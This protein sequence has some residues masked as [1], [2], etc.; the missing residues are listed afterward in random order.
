MPEKHVSSRM[1]K[2]VLE[3]YVKDL[4][5]SIININTRSKTNYQSLVTS[6][7]KIED[8]IAKDF[9]NDKNFTSKINNHKSLIKQI[10][11]NRDKNITEIKKVIDEFIKS[12]KFVSDFEKLKLKKLKEFTAWVVQ[13]NNTK[14]ELDNFRNKINEIFS[15]SVEDLASSAEFQQDKLNVYISI[16]S[17]GLIDTTGS[18][19]RDILFTL[20]KT[21]NFIELL[22]NNDS[23]LTSEKGM[24]NPLDTEILFPSN[25]FEDNTPVNFTTNQY[26]EFEM[27][28]AEKKEVKVQVK[29]L[30]D[31]RSTKK[32]LSK[33]K[34][35]PIRVTI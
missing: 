25:I 33:L 6:I 28:V 19:L 31:L 27:Y 34:I 22:A 15:K 35:N 1:I 3:P 23:S 16:L 4:A 32:S 17:L 13:S 9:I 12:E 29:K 2:L 5:I 14:V 7:L 18:T 26:K 8:D 21:I 10:E 20:A 11:F 24:I 30:K